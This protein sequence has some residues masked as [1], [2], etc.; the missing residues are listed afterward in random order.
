MLSQLEADAAVLRAAVVQAKAAAAASNKPASAITTTSSVRH[1]YRDSLD[2]EGCM[3]SDVSGTT[4]HRDTLLSGSG[5][6]ASALNS[7]SRAA[8]GHQGVSAEG[9]GDKPPAAVAS[10]E[11]GDGDA[12]QWDDTTPVRDQGNTHRLQNTASCREQCAIP[13]TCDASSAV[14]SS[15]LLDNT[16]P[17]STTAKRTAAEGIDG[18]SVTAAAAAAAAPGCLPSVSAALGAM[19]GDLVTVDVL[20]PCYRVDTAVLGIMAQRVR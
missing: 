10:S 14:S 19:R 7:S 4:D 2:P 17:P 11:G 12:G 5:Q 20:V 9:P 8:S 13:S 18:G 16:T 1:M 15:S 3:T 6:W